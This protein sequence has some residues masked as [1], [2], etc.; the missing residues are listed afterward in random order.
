MSE[1]LTLRPISDADVDATVALWTACGL[2][3]PWNDPLKD[4]VF[5][6]GQPN[7]EVLVARLDG[8]LVASVMVGHDGHRGMVYYVSVHPDMQ[9][10]GFGRQVMAAAETWLKAR[11]VWK[12]NLL[13]RAENDKVRGFYE[14]LGY[15]VE[16]RLCMA[17]KLIGPEA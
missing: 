10:R 6:R 16:P 4:I 12:L 1:S 9:G 7:S 15:E 14:S 8:R 5:A 2:V 11:G 17:R 3:R 13:V